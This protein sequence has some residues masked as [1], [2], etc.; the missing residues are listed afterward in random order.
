VGAEEVD[1]GRRCEPLEPGLEVHEG[2]VGGL[3]RLEAGDDRGAAVVRAQ[4]QRRRG[5]PL[6]AVR[7]RRAA[8]RDRHRARTARLRAIGAIRVAGGVELRHRSL[9]IQPVDAIRHRLERG[10]GVEQQRRGVPGEPEGAQDR[11]AGGGRLPLCRLDQ[12]ARRGAGDHPRPHVRR[13]RHPKA[14]EPQCAERS[15]FGRRAAAERLL[16]RLDQSDQYRP[17]LE[18]VAIARLEGAQHGLVG[19]RPRAQRIGDM[20]DQDADAR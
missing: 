19:V 18:L 10:L 2:D 13:D 16:D 14:P 9:G 4:D 20:R 7:A 1:E 8:Q 11:F 6:R 3:E 5:V 12:P 17:E 15:R